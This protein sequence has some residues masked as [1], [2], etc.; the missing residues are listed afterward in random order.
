MFE[1]LF[2]FHPG[3]LEK[4]PGAAAP[5]IAEDLFAAPGLNLRRERGLASPFR[6]KKKRHTGFWLRHLPIYL[7][8]LSSFRLHPGLRGDLS[9]LKGR[10]GSQEGYGA[11]GT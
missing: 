4:E 6:G 7:D 1:G 2:Y 9:K 11:T 10:T 8:F 5:R 3:F